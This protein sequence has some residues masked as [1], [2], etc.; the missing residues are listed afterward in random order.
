MG[1]IEKKLKMGWLE[2]AILLV[3]V[4]LKEVRCHGDQPLSKIAI[5]K[6]VFALHDHAYVK[7]TP[8]VLGLKVTFSIAMSVFSSF[9]HLKVYA[10]LTLLGT[11]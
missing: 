6:A 2:L 9:N 8:T 5:H 11:K 4:T 3:L 10:V 7:A 1:R